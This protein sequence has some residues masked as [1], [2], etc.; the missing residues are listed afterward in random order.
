M[1]HSSCDAL[2]FSLLQGFSQGIRLGSRKSI[3]FLRTFPASILHLAQVAMDELDGHCSLT[4]A[5]G[6]TLDGAVTHIT[7][8]K[9]PRDAGL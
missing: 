4:N 8:S 1:I 5:G 7:G 6:D 9:D 2:K 3:T